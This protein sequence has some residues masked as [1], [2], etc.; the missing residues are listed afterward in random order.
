MQ[1]PGY[2][3]Q[4]EIGRG[5]M[6]SVHL[7]I[8]ESCDRPVAIKIMSA[9]LANDPAFAKRFI[10]EAKT[11]AQLSH[12]H[13]VPVFDTGLHDDCHY[14]T[15]EHIVGGTLKKKIR[16]QTL[17]PEQAERVLKEIA[18]ALDYAGEQDLIHRDVKPD[19]IMFRGDGSAVL[20][21]FGIARPTLSDDALTQ[22]G[23][24]VGTPRYMSP[25]QHRGK[26]IDHRSDL[27]ALGAVL[28]EMLTGKPPY[29]ADDPMALGIKHISEPFPL[30]PGELRR[31]Q[32]LLRKLLAK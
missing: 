15:M 24:V 26:D 17:T 19:N 9:T 28:F 2:L 27:Y 18:S 16:D 3:V 8:Q 20:M 23:T 13:I 5:G 11:M 7:A 10:R 25:E 21:D 22:I 14:M 29:T 4:A 31:Y 1:I 30:L 6:A 12:P 32:P